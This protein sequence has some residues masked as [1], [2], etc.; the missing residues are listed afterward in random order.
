MKA[1]RAALQSERAWLDDAIARL[2]ATAKL[3]RHGLEARLAKVTEDLALAKS[4]EGERLV[5]LTFRGAPV[6]GSRSIE[7]TFAGRA[8]SLFSEAVALG[9]AGFLQPVGT[10]GPIPG[11]R[12]RRLRVVGPA[13]GSFGFELELPE[14]PVELHGLPPGT[15][16]EALALRAALSVLQ[17]AVSGDQT[18][19]DELISVGYLRAARKLGELVKLA[20]DNQALFAVEFD[21]RR[22]AIPDEESARVAANLLR[23]EG[24]HQREV[25]FRAQ[26]SGLRAT[27]PD[28]ECVRLETSQTLLGLVGAWVDLAALAGLVGRTAVFHFLETQSPGGRTNYLLTGVD[29]TSVE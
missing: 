7:A 3:T 24:V 8:L 29:L 26:L 9:A 2:P 5:R 19:L 23:S 21:A 1:S 28:F 14:A 11:A 27:K 17:D 4:V 25:S 12:D 6:E 10:T 22:V 15:H 13:T 16:P 18:N 20:A